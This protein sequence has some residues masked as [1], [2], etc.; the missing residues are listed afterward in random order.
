MASKNSVL[1][2]RDCRRWRM[3]S[4]QAN[5]SGRSKRHRPQF[6][7]TRR[8][9]LLR[10]PGS[11]W[12]RFRSRRV[13]R[14]CGRREPRTSILAKKMG[15][16]PEVFNRVIWK[17]LMGDKPYPTNRSGVDLRQHRAQLLKSQSTASVASWGRTNAS[18]PMQAE[19]DWDPLERIHRHFIFV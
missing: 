6:C 1:I 19:C 10:R 5:R 3:L 11:I 4:I 12:L 16:D 8:C 9:Q 7:S 18:A 17:G 14:P 15:V 13:T 2:T